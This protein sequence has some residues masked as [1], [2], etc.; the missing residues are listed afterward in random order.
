MCLFLDHN[1]TGKTFLELTRN[2]LKEIVSQIGTVAE[3]HNLQNVQ[4]QQRVTKV[5]MYVHIH[6]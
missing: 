2:E 6:T 3:L 1:V 4:K 5:H